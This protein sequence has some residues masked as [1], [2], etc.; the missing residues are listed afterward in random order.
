MNISISEIMKYY[1][2]LR[3]EAS[4]KNNPHLQQSHICLLLFKIK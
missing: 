2:S 4:L 3:E 1:E